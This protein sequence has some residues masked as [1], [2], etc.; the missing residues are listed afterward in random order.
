MKYML[1]EE[2]Y[3]KLNED[4][5]YNK[6]TLSNLITD[7]SHAFVVKSTRVEKIEREVL[8]IK[9]NI[10]NLI[11]I[12]N[13]YY[14][15]SRITD[16]IKRYLD[17]NKPIIIENEKHININLKLFG[18]DTDYES[19][20]SLNVEDYLSNLSKDK[21]FDADFKEMVC[22]FA[23]KYVGKNLYIVDSIKDDKF[24]ILIE[25]EEDEIIDR[26]EIGKIIRR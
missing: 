13:K 25:N 8:D 6:N 12:M 17:E 16:G 3:K 1:N 20:G 18:I 7:L 15:N 24:Y 22:K 21:E 9:L 19:L 5:E 11:D 2:E 10:N 23:F 4:L 14:F 26:L